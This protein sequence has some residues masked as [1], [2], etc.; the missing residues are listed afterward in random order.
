MVTGEAD[1][2][3]AVEGAVG[4]GVAIVDVAQ[5]VDQKCAD[6]GFSKG[7]GTECV[8][9]LGTVQ[10]GPQGVARGGSLAVS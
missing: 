9:F 5:L 7:E 8:E 1:A 2:G 4:E 3:G 10:G 6:L